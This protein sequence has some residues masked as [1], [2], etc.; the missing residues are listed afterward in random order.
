MINLAFGM[1]SVCF[2][3]ALLPAVARRES[4]P[5][6]TCLLTAFWLWVFAACYWS[7]GYT[8][9]LVADGATALLWTVLALQHV[10]LGGWLF[11]GW[12]S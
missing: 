7:L 12:L 1:G 11:D 8:F 4:P 10:R 9:S 5:L 6:S 3:L 2:A